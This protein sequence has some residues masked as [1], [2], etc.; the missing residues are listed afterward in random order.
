MPK[1]FV[2]P[3]RVGMIAGATLLAGG[4]IA[5]QF[6]DT[7]WRILGSKESLRISDASGSFRILL[8]KQCIKHYLF[9]TDIK[10][11]VFGF[12]PDCFGYWYATKNI[13]IP[14]AGG[15]FMD[16]VFT[17]AHNDYLTAVIN[18]GIPGLISYLFVF[19]S[20]AVNAVNSLLRKKE[21][22]RAM[23]LLL[24]LIGY[25]VNNAFSFQTVCATPI[26]FIIIGLVMAGP[27]DES[28]KSQNQ[29]SFLF[30]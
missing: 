1:A 2:L 16:A 7:L 11:F 8:W 21:T 25:A 13:V 24:I 5:V 23:L 22:K 10:H 15:P 28:I 20:I 29:N 14:V 27:G 9:E 12:G 6:S 3:V 30:S 17:N 18:L 19:L 26:F 4:L